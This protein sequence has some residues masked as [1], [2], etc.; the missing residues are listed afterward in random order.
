MPSTLLKRYSAICTLKEYYMFDVSSMD[1]LSNGGC[2][3]ED[4]GVAR[5]P[6]EEVIVLCVARNGEFTVVNCTMGLL[7]ECLCKRVVLEKDHNMVTFG[8]VFFKMSYKTN[9]GCEGA[10]SKG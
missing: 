3:H 4:F 1:A 9:K 7:S 10:N 8:Q 6:A 2:C 5:V